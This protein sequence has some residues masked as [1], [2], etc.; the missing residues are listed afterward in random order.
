MVNKLP[1]RYYIIKHLKAC[2]AEHSTRKSLLLIST[3]NN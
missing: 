1:P 3:H 2:A